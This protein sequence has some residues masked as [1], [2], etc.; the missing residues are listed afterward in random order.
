MEKKTGSQRKEWL[1]ASAITLALLIAAIIAE[2]WY[3]SVAAVK[4][5]PMLLVWAAD[6]VGAILLLF[7]IRGF[8]GK[9][10]EWFLS[11]AVTLVMLGLAVG[12]EYWYTGTTGIQLDMAA[13]WGGNVV[14]GFLMLFIVHHFVK[15][16]AENDT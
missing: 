4:L 1:I 6:F 3:N 10:K 12:G 15:D 9:P 14:G 16:P 11:L 2:L 5:K 13:V 8:I 7:V